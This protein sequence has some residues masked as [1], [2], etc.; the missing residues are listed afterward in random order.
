MLTLKQREGARVIADNDWIL[1]VGGARSG[2]TFLAIKKI[3]V[4]AY[5][6]DGSRFLILRR[7]AVD[8]RDSIFSITIPAVLKDLGLEHGVEYSYTKLPMQYTFSNGSTII[9]AGLD[10]EK[11]AEKVLGQEYAFIYVNE[12]NTIS[13]QVIKKLKTRLSQNTKAGNKFICDLNPESTN[14]WTYK[15]WYKGVDPES[16]NKID[17]MDE[18]GVAVRFGKI[19]MNPY[20]NRSNLPDGYIEKNLETLSG[21]ARNRFLLGEYSTDSDIKVFKPASLYEWSEF[22]DW[23]IGKESSIRFIGGL[24][25]GFQDA[26]AFCIIAYVDGLRDHWVVYEHKA[27]R[28]NI[29]ELAEAMKRGI[30]WV[31]K[32]IPTNNQTI[33]FYCDTATLRHGHEGDQKKTWSQLRS[34]YGLP[35]SAAYK[36]DKKLSTEFLI[37]EV[38]GGFLHIPHGGSLNDEMDMTVFTRHDDGT[39]ERV[40]NDEIYHPDEVDAVVYC[41]NFLMSYGNK[42]FFDRI[43]NHRKNDN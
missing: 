29:D 30:D 15:L 5:Q 16:G 28:Q 43:D 21:N 31:F 22:K 23:M 40:I 1:L 32:N 9:C 8:I 18:K 33:Q 19:Q 27:R 26:D 11:A 17:W 20:D 2:K 4:S 12:C 14:H 42:V 25:L 34:M 13:W 3:I 36:R 24:D 10:D 7:F 35:V 38:D 41:Y 6:H 39:I 37:S